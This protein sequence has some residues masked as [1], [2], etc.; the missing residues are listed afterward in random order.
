MKFSVKPRFQLNNAIHGVHMIT[1]RNKHI[2][3]NIQR[4]DMKYIEKMKENHE[5]HIFINWFMD[6]FYG[7][8]NF[9]EFCEEVYRIT[10]RKIIIHI[11]RKAK[12]VKYSI[13]SKLDGFYGYKIVTESKP[14][15][16]MVYKKYGISYGLIVAN[17]YRCSG[18]PG[19][20]D[21]AFIS[22]LSDLFPKVFYSKSDGKE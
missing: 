22:V 16:F 8:D 7:K 2:L 17:E 6:P 13:T 4:F 11:W 15:S 12:P 20:K 1:F 5:V 18:D 19:I 14:V 9:I 10:K 3:I 21:Y